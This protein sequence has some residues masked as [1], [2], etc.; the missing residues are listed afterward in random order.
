MHM[1]KIEGK[2]EINVKIKFKDGFFIS[3]VSIEQIIKE[4]VKSDASIENLVKSEV[5]QKDG[6]CAHCGIF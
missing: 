4:T 5:E 6:V 2:K 3:K 1:S